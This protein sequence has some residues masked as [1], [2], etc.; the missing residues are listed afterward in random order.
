M[1]TGNGRRGP[2]PVAVAPAALEVFRRP[3]KSPSER[4]LALGS[5]GSPLPTTIN[6]IDLATRGGPRPGGVVVLGGPP[7]SGKTGLLMYLLYVWASRLVPVTVLAADEAADGL[8]IRVGQQLGLDREA[9]ERGDV[10]TLRRLAQA[11]ERWPHLSLFDADDD[12][13]AVEDATYDL[14][15]KT[16]GGVGVLLVDS[17]Q[18][19]RAAGTDQASDP[20]QEANAVVKALKVAAKRGLLVVATSELSRAAYRSKNADEL[21]ADI[22]SF[23]ESGGIEHVAH[24]AMVMRERD[25]VF[26]ITMPKN[27]WGG[28]KPR[29]RLAMDPDRASFVEIPVPSDLAPLEM[30]SEAQLERDLNVGRRVLRENPGIAGKD[31]LRA[32]MK[33]MGKGRSSEVIRVLEQAG[34]IEDRGER[35]SPR[36][37]LREASHPDPPRSPSPP[38]DSGHHSPPRSPLPYRG[39]DLGEGW[40]GG[41]AAG[42]EG[43]ES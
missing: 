41:H 22:A 7:G 13:A 38:G 36:L 26:D 11:L 2:Q 6:T 10:A 32:A 30:N 1:G 43:G 20:R 17:I 9:L 42:D 25:G 29:L 35:R 28:Q 33:G 21:V 12:E 19:V 4:A 27:R 24:L 16:G 14:L 37:F 34:E 31:R 8:L 39:G 23:K 15:G 18:K 3:G 5:L 40:R